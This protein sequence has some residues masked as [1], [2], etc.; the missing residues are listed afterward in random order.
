[1]EDKPHRIERGS[2]LKLVKGYFYGLMVQLF[3]YF[4]SAFDAA[5]SRHVQVYEAS[6]VCRK[7]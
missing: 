3:I 2:C 4:V 7:I 1:M 6:S 5:A